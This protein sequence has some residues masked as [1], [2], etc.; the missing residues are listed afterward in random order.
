[1]PLKISSVFK[2]FQA[3]AQQRKHQFRARGYKTRRYMVAPSG[4]WSASFSSLASDST[5]VPLRFH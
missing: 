1:M 5:V 2:S 4:Y 3:I